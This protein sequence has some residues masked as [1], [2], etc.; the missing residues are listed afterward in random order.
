MDTRFA[1]LWGK[2]QK[3][4]TPLAAVVVKEKTREAI[5]AGL[6]ARRV[7]ATSGARILLDAQADGHDM[8]EE[9][10][11]ES[12]PAFKVSVVGTSPLKKVAIKRVFAKRYSW[13]EQVPAERERGEEIYSHRLELGQREAE[14]T[15]RY[16]GPSQTAYYYVLVVQEDDEQ[17]VSSP[18]L[19][20]AK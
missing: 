15:F 7:Y 2:P 18:I 14:F 11:T 10:Q 20:L 19:I 6:F 8:G 1:D 5:F 9:Y 3:L 16:P 4:T 17:A 12:A 13:G